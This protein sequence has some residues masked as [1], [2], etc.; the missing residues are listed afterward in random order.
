MTKDRN[1]F[2]VAVVF[3]AAAVGASGLLVTPRDRSSSERK[4]RSS[5]QSYSKKRDD[6]DDDSGDEEADDEAC[7]ESR[8]RLRC[9]KGSSWP[10]CGRRLSRRLGGRP[11]VSPRRQY[12]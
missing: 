9:R 2:V 1:S 11:V 6:D 7:L 4:L 10:S 12:A 5:D 8:L 3:D